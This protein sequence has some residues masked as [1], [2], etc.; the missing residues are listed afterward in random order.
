VTELNRFPPVNPNGRSEARII[1][2]A[3][4]WLLS[5]GANDKIE[6]TL[7][8]NS[9][10]TVLTDPRLGVGS[11]LL[12]MPLTANAAAALAGMYPSVQATGTMTLTHA[13]NAQADRSFRAIISR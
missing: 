12:P 13:N 2:Q 4:N 7:T 5:G 6:F 1:A 8:E 3:I 10:T 11:V 9:A